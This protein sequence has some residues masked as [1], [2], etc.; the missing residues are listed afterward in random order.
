MKEVIQG[1]SS[2]IHLGD[3]KYNRGH[4]YGI[5]LGTDAHPEKGFLMTTSYARESQDPRLFIAAAEGITYQNSFGHYQGL[6]FDETIKRVLFH[7]GR[8]FVF[9]DKKEFYEWLAQ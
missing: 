4:Y 7:D 6:R 1:S 3:L 5:L 9:E 8:V 2:T